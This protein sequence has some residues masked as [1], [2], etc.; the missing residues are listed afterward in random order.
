MKY[1][2]CPECGE[3]L[4]E[5]E[6][7]DEGLIPYCNTCKKPYFEKV[8]QSVL[9]NVVNECNEVLLLKQ[10]YVSR[11]NWV[12]VA[13]YIKKGET[14]EET[15]IREVI[16]ETGQRS[17][18]LRYI[19]SYYYE[20]HELLMLGYLMKVE[21]GDFSKSIE[22]DELKWFSFDDAIL[23]LRCGSIGEKHLLNCLK[24]I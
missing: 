20:K 2:F 19:K 5:K 13:G 8:G 21:K 10:N 7:G 24:C 3:M 15:A 12:L 22:V 6:L 9:V 17:D 4:I 14:A 23:K 11:T 16:E 18:K 1:K